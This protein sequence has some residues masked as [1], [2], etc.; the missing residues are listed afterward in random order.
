MRWSSYRS[1]AGRISQ[2]YSECGVRISQLYSECETGL[3]L[4]LEHALV[5]RDWRVWGHSSHYELAQLGIG[6]QC[7]VFSEM[8]N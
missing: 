7:E 6:V 2:L 3:R 5:T 8:K 1:I 4:A